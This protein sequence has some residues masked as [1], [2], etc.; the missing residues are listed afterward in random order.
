M[1]AFRSPRARLALAFLPA[2]A[3]AARPG[4]AEAQERQTDRGA[5]TWSARLD[6]GAW[7]MVRNLNGSVTVERG[8]SDRVEVV[9]TKSWRRTNPE[10]VRIEVK[11]YGTGDRNALVCAVWGERTTCDENRYNR[12]NDNNGRSGSNNNDVSVAFVVKV[13]AGVR[14]HTSTVNGA[15]E[16]EGATSEVR[17][18]TVNGAV[19]VR[20]TGG[21]V[22]ASTVNGSVTAV[23]GRFDLRE[24]LSFSSVNG[25][26]RVSFAELPNA[27]VEMSTVNGSAVTDF[28]ITVQGRFNR[29]TIRGEI[30]QGGPRVRLSTVNGAVELRQQ[31]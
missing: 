9:A 22:E 18:S 19:R 12:T 26:V 10:S 28:P 25:A 24:D 2:L 31:R 11:R 21:P 23:M 30:G 14:V 7:I 4:A 15:V 17:A 8:T 1:R 3:L 13:P 20:S 5:F 29:R 16:I 27:S 6:E